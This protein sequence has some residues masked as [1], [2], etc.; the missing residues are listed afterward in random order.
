MSSGQPREL[1]RSAFWKTA[2]QLLQALR[3]RHGWSYQE[4]AERAG[5]T[6]DLVV[7]YELARVR[8]PELEACWRITTTLGVDLPV[9]LR[10]VEKRSK[11]SLIAGI[12]PFAAGGTQPMTKQAV[13]EPPSTELDALSDFVRKSGGEE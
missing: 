3:E 1:A 2:G 8:F 12:R 13:E 5:V 6:A 10:E 11:V 7:A 9:F 4:L